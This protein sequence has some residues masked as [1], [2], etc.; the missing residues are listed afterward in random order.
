MK[1]ETLMI[2]ITRKKIQ[3]YLNTIIPKKNHT[4]MKT[5]S[6][7]RNFKRKNYQILIN[8]R[9]KIRIKISRCIIKSFLISIYNKFKHIL[10]HMIYLKYWKNYLL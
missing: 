9:I 7:I 2:N 4:P 1:T 10:L 3:I 6:T 8:L 5:T